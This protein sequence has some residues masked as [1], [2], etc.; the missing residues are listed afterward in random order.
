MKSNYNTIY[1]KLYNKYMYMCVNEC[2][3]VRARALERNI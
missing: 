2:V 1:I 3:C